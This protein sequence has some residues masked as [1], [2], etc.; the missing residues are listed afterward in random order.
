MPGFEHFQFTGFNLNNAVSFFF[1][2]S[3]FI[4]SLS[5]H[6]MDIR[7][8]FKRFI[9]SRFARVYP[10]HVFMFII[11]FSLFGPNIIFDG[12]TQFIPVAFANLTLI[13]SWFPLSQYYFSY[14]AVSW[15]ISTEFAFYFA[16]PFLL[17]ASRRYG[18]LYLLTPVAITALLLGASFITGLHQSSPDGN[19]TS[20]GTLYISPLSRLTEF[21]FGMMM[22]EFY[23]ISRAKRFGTNTAT[24]LEMLAIAIAFSSAYWLSEIGVETKGGVYD[25]IGYWL[26]FAGSFVAIGILVLVYARQ[27]G[28]LSRTLKNPY[29]VY[30][31]EISFSL[32]MCH[33]LILSI[34][35]NYALSFIKEHP[36]AGYALYWGLS[37]A[38]SSALYRFVETPSRYKIR[39]VFAGQI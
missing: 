11:Y 7:K 29:L 28:L 6:K 20:T 8:D 15:S 31:G 23:L 37:L 18:S 4:M 17:A 27:E 14:N 1:V 38:L 12:A 22:Y 35:N 5:Y 2:L 39:K 16:F 25:A 34:A 21:A 33:R 10:V 32:Y 9:A 13:Q 36:F 19:M 3:G 26:S 24:F 30:L